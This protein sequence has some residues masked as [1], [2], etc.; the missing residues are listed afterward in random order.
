VNYFLYGHNAKFTADATYLPNGLPVNDDG[1]G[2][3]Q[4]NRHNEIIA[5]VQFQLLL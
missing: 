1:S 5:R 2:A 4:S 3:L